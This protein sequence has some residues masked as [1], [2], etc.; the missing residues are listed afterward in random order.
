[1][2]HPLGAQEYRKECIYSK[3]DIKH[4]NTYR[5][6]E[7]QKKT[8]KQQGGYTTTRRDKALLAITDLKLGKTKER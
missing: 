1:M 3:E 4:Q 5:R 6:K 7:R 2:P 8:K